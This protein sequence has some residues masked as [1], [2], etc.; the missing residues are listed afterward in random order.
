VIKTFV[1]TYDEAP[2]S[3]NA[4]G[5]GS[6]SH[7]SKGYAEKRRWEGIWAL[8][9]IE[10]K[11]PRGM[12]HCSVE[13]LIEFVRAQRRDV[14][15]YRPALVKAFADALVHGGWLPDDEERFFVMAGL[16]LRAGMESG[17]PFVQGRTTLTLQATYPDAD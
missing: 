6:R 10:G 12:T 15:N 3:L 13:G 2:K 11:V 9:L 4:G 16:T 17:N 5:A 8:L 14:E 1:L 7:W